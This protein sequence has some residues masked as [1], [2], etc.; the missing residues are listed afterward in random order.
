MVY[1]IAK[2]LQTIAL[3]ATLYLHKI[4]SSSKKSMSQA[5]SVIINIM[6][7]YKSTR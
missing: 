1:G 5:D 3:V 7:G 6:P 2:T 4:I